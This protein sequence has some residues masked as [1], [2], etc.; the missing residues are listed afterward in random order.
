MLATGLPAREIIA[1]EP[2]L[3]E[4]DGLEVAGA[5][6]RLYEQAAAAVAAAH[7]AGREEAYSEVR[8]AEG[9]AEE[10]GSRQPPA[11]P[12]P[13]WRCRPRPPRRSFGRPRD[14]KEGGG[15]KFDRSRPPRRDK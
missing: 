10:G 3:T 9:R 2:L 4:Y 1:L 13:R 7:L 5:A 6:L 11:T 8:A 12:R 14:G 15:R